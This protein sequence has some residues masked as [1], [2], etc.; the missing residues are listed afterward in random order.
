MSAS[1]RPCNCENHGRSEGEA[2]G[3]ALALV[4]RDWPGFQESSRAR[5]REIDFR[6]LFEHAR[7][8]DRVAS[9]VRK[10][11]VEVWSAAAVTAIQAYDPEVVIYGGGVMDAAEEIL[12]PIRSFIHEHARTPWGKAGVRAAQLGEDAAVLGAVPLLRET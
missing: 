1:A 8:G 10:R 12:P 3:W 5:A 11:C 7:S 6:A 4:C 9:E 2:S